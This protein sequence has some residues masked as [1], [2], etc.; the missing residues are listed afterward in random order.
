MEIA[1]FTDS[2]P[3]THDGVATEVSALGRALVRLGHGVRVFAPHPVKGEPPFD[4]VVDG[5]PVI[6]SRSLPVPYY[7]QYRW[8]LFPFAQLRGRGLS[9][10]VDIVHLH[11]PGIMGS[12]GFL[13]SRRLHKPLVGTFHTNVWAM[14]ESFPDALPVRLFFRAAWWYTLGTYYRCNA[15]TAP[16]EDAAV[17]LTGAMGKPLRRPVEVIP[18]GIEVDRF[19]PGVRVP[20][21]RARCALPEGPTVTFLGRLTADKGI[22]RFLDAVEEIASHRPVT[23]LVAGVGPEEAAVRARLARGPLA[24]VARYVGPVA[25]EEKPALLAQ[26]EIFVL[27]STSDTSSISVLEAMASGA[28]CV[29]SD[30]GGLPSVVREGETGRIVPLD[31]PGAL[32]GAIAHLLAAGAERARLSLQA[33]EWVRRTASIEVTARRAWSLI[34]EL[35]DL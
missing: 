5:V 31:P 20:D 16:T 12:V 27:P 11:T 26:S 32:S 9:K 15:T 2:Y 24:R 34:E 7:A 6:R 10:E 30:Q 19:R 29:T 28:A 22:H 23:A 3:P 4:E 18:N 33:R 13:A 25:E 8:G 14:R 35:L 21:W 17:T 1:F